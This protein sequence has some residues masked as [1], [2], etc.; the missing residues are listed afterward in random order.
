MKVTARDLINKLLDFDLSKIWRYGIYWLLHIVALGL[1]LLLYFSSP[2]AKEMS[3]IEFLKFFAWLFGGAFVFD[4]V[5][6]YWKWKFIDLP[7][8]TD[9]LIGDNKKDGE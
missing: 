5:K 3:G 2:P 1:L 8:I 9:I 4:K 7:Q 6:A